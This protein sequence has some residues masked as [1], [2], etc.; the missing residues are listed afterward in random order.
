M[1]LAPMEL[2][3]LLICVGRH[4]LFQNFKYKKKIAFVLSF[5]LFI[6]IFIFLFIFI[7]I[8]FFCH[9]FFIAH[10]C[11]HFISLPQFSLKVINAG[12]AESYEE[13][14]QSCCN[15]TAMYPYAMRTIP[16]ACALWCCFPFSACTFIL[17]RIKRAETPCAVLVLLMTR[18]IWAFLPRSYASQFWQY[19]LKMLPRKLMHDHCLCIDDHKQLWITYGPGG[20]RTR[21]P[22]LRRPVLCPCWA[23]GPFCFFSSPFKIK[24]LL[25]IRYGWRFSRRRWEEIRQLVSPVHQSLVHQYGVSDHKQNAYYKHCLKTNWWSCDFPEDFGV[26]ICAEAGADS[27]VDMGAGVGTGISMRFCICSVK[28]L[29]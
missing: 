22:R 24:E 18:I 25:Q 16:Y 9:T 26:V 23:T 4:L 28:S 5:F 15:I 13:F 17:T 19:L 1:E 8:F 2:E 10:C 14:H 11:S 29:I 3:T 21:D 6:F 20:T 7:L 27:D 12:D